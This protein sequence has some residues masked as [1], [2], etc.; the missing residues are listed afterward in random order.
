MEIFREFQLNEAESMFNQENT[1]N[2][3]KQKFKYKMACIRFESLKTFLKMRMISG[4]RFI[5]ALLMRNTLKKELFLMDLEM[6]LE[7]LIPY[8]LSQDQ[9]PSSYRYY[10]SILMLI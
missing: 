3:V 10:D 8:E 1:T 6:G 5:E 2:F 4:I 9:W 7:T